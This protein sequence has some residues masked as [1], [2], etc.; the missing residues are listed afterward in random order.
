MK[1]WKESL[2]ECISVSMLHN[3][4]EATTLPM[5]FTLNGQFLWRLYLSLQTYKHKSFA[6]YQEG[7]RK[8]VERAF[9]NL[10]Y[11]NSV[12]SL[13][14]V[15][16]GCGSKCQ[17]QESWKLVIYYTQYNIIFQDEKEL[18]LTPLELNE[19][20]GTSIVLPPKVQLLF[21][22]GRKPAQ[23]CGHLIFIIYL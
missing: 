23:M 4:I 3:M 7:A 6:K 8:D 19:T 9:G 14:A 17:S 5:E 10:V 20:A 11:C 21:E 1:S 22:L 12:L 2:W 16:H 15:Q 13:Y 18:V